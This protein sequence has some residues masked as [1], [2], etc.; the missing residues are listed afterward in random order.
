[1]HCAG[2]SSERVVPGQGI[3]AAERESRC[4]PCRQGVV[5]VVL[6]QL[7]PVNLQKHALFVRKAGQLRAG[8]RGAK[9]V[10]RVKR[11]QDPDKD[12]IVEV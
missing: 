8:E 1:M 12:G 9:P 5:A 11:P 6:S 2:V 7:I 10:Q 3:R 4:G